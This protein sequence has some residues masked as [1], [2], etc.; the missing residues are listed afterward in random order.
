MNNKWTEVWINLIRHQISNQLSTEWPC[1]AMQLIYRFQSIL[2]PLQSHHRSITVRTSSLLSMAIAS[3][4]T[5]KASYT[6][7]RSP[8]ISSWPRRSDDRGRSLERYDD[9]RFVT[10]PRDG[11]IPTVQRSWTCSGR[12]ALRVIILYLTRWPGPDKRQLL[13][14][15]DLYFIASAMAVFWVDV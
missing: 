13:D 11:H 7:H 9:H 3:C 14:D 1:P 12:N 6:M 10:A 8:G 4:H 2:H 5:F 15:M